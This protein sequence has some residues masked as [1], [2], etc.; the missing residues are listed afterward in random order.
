MK[1]NPDKFQAIAIGPKTNKYNLS[2]DLNNFLTVLKNFL[3]DHKLPIL[4]L[5]NCVG[6]SQ[7]LLI[8]PLKLLQ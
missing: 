1:A 5:I 2:F 6:D 3:R 4:T 7:M 8:N